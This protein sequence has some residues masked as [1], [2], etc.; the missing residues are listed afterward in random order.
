M[1]SLNGRRS[2]LIVCAVALLLA[3]CGG[4]Q[5]LFGVPGAMPMPTGKQPAELDRASRYQVLFRF[6][7]SRV[8]HDGWYPTDPL[9]YLN[10]TFYGTTSAGGFSL[11]CRSCGYGVIFRLSPSGTY[12]R[13]HQFKGADGA[14]PAGGVTDVHGTLYGTTYSGGAYGYGAIFSVTPRGEYHLLYSFNFSNSSTGSAGPLGNLVDVNGILYGTAISAGSCDCGEVYSIS[15]QGK[16]QTLH[17]FSGPDGS[18]PTAGLLNVDGALYGTTMS[19]GAHKRGTVFRIST[20]GVE[21]V[22][23]SFDGADGRGPSAPLIAVNGRLYGTT[24]YGGSSGWGTVFSMTM[25]GKKE[26]VLHSFSY[27]NDGARPEAGLIDMNATFYG[28]TAFGGIYNRDVCHGTCGTIFSVTKKGEEHV[29]YDFAETYQN[30]GATPA[31]NLIEVKGRLYGT[32]EFGG[33][34]LNCGSYPCY[35]GTVFA[36]TP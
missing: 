21:K 35:D 36:I 9:L 28:T 24:Q 31:A 1:K 18:S 6:G 2:A 23:F 32:T 20:T 12:K 33:Y 26:R 5:K 11:K 8:G 3:G 29:V 10:G 13:V 15:T 30:D 34:S 14:Y 16:F 22:L 7:T 27:A 17:V 25:D 4:S 19:G